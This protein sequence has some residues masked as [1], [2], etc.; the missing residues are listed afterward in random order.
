MINQNI[1][2]ALENLILW[3]YAN[4]RWGC[5]P[6]EII[7]A[8]AALKVMKDELARADPYAELKAAAQDPSK[9]IRIKREGNK[10]CDY[11]D[12]WEFCFP[13]EVYEIRDKP[14]EKKTVKL[15]AWFAGIYLVWIAD[16]D[17]VGKD[18]LRVS[19]LDKEIEVEPCK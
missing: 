15:Q 17:V 13:P 14:K 19:C 3:A 5:T 6:T 4:H 2:R 12:P 8:E 18:W 16:G 11:T 7:Y 9:Q 10:W 1:Q